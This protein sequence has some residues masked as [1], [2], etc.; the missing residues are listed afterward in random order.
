M[1]MDKEQLNLIRLQ[2]KTE[3]M[4]EFLT[5]IRSHVAGSESSSYLYSTLTDS[6]EKIFWG[7]KVLKDSQLASYVKYTSL[8]E[9]SALVKKRA[10]LWAMRKL[11]SQVDGNIHLGSTL[12][13]SEKVLL[14]EANKVLEQRIVEVE[15]DLEDSPSDYASLELT[16]K[17]YKRARL[18]YVNALASALTSDQQAA[19]ILALEEG[20]VD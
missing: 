20:S 7:L 2:E 8:S 10:R 12:G 19:R 18:L 13:V 6:F 14:K 3:L 5:S 15:K 9:P 11:A 4:M 1:E 16:R 17:L